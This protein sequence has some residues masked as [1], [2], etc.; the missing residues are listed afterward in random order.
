[1][2]FGPQPP[3]ETVLQNGDSTAK[4]FC[5]LQDIYIYIYIYIYTH[6][7]IVIFIT[8]QDAVT[9]ITVYTSYGLTVVLKYLNYR[10][11]KNQIPPHTTPF[12]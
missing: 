7:H 2:C 1:M 11:Y 5:I 10:K 8:N 4:A 9:E 6:T 3:G 12:F